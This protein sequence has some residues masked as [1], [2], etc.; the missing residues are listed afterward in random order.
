MRRKGSAILTILS[1]VVVLAILAL[2][3]I[4]SKSEKAGISKHLSDEKKAEA[5]AESATD[6]IISFV[7]RNCNN[8]EVTGASNGLYYLLRAPLKYKGTPGAVNNVTLEIP[9][10]TGIDDLSTYVGYEEIL[11][12]VIQEIG[13]EGKVKIE[14]KCEL[15]SAEAFTPLNSGYKVVGINQEHFPATGNTAK[16]LDTA[17]NESISFSGEADD[18]WKPSDWT[19]N[20]KFPKEDQLEEKVTFDV[21]VGFTGLLDTEAELKATRTAET[22]EESLNLTLDLDI[23]GDFIVDNLLNDTIFGHPISIQ[24][25]MNGSHYFPD[26]R[27]VN[28]QG[29]KNRIVGDSNPQ[30]ELAGYVSEIA[31][32]YSDVKNAF[33]KYDISSDNFGEPMV[34]E[35][36]GILRITT[37]VEYQK[38]ENNKIT[39]TLVSE[40]PFKVSDV[41]PIAP[42]YTFFVA[43]SQLLCNPDDI[44]PSGHELGKPFNMNSGA[45]SLTT[46]NAKVA[47]GRLIVHNLQHKNGKPTFQF[48]DGRCPGMV[49]INS[50]YR[51][52]GDETNQVRSFLGVFEEPNL[53]EL[54]KF[55]TPYDS[56]KPGDYDVNKFN[57]LISFV[58]DPDISNTPFKR[59]H[60]VEFPLLFEL[61]AHPPASMIPDPGVLGF[62]DYFHEGN[63]SIISVPTLLFGDG[64]M[65]YPLGINAEGPITSVYSRIRVKVKPSIKVKPLFKDT[66]EIYYDYEPVST[67]AKSG[68]AIYPFDETGNDATQ[69]EPTP[70]GMQGHECYKP[71]EAWNSNTDP[72]YMPTFCYDAMQYAK[73]ATRYYDTAE[74]FIS[75][76]GR[77][78]DKNGLKDSSGNVELNGVFYIK[79]GNL[80]LNGFTYTGNGLIV[81]KSSNIIINGDIKRGTSTNS[82]GNTNSTLGIIARTG[83]IQFNCSSVEAACFSNNAPSAPGGSAFKLYGNMV[84]NDFD[85][86]RFTATDIYYDNTL[87]SVTPLASMRKVGKFEPKR[88]IVAFDDNWSKFAYEK[89]NKNE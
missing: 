12:P 54:N 28:M 7:K 35:K 78:K 8:E 17:P 80:N 62:I 46:H 66:T 73:K 22:G 37:M 3:F 59:Y 85:R 53:S 5:L 64:G 67:Y 63:F 36:G 79:S 84:C 13:W 15:S 69:Y 57:T 20:I 89:T 71:N 19:L 11:A 72:K 33:S 47:V 43:N 27:P 87:T 14:T 26:V 21:E 49:R 4:G 48:D 9:A 1:V 88:Y 25:K 6:L 40:A 29:L 86:L 39:K 34:I 77:S 42:E 74:E 76:M 50:Q 24:D 60:E 70:Y 41:Q 65:E 30:F 18:K 52:T 32:R 38:S 58:W 83:S 44:L 82:T 75:D 81:S 16:F 10:D 55:F 31:D 51:N 56:N 2:S 61:P 23:K 68:D 45:D